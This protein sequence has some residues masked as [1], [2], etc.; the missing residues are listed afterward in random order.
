MAPRGAGDFGV[1]LSALRDATSAMVTSR[2][3]ADEKAREAV[4][5]VEASLIFAL[6]REALRGLPDLG[7][8]IHGLRIGVEGSQF[9]KLPRGRSV[10]VLDSKG[11]LVWA[12]MFASGTAFVQRAPRA[13]I[14]ASILVPYMGAVGRA[15][16]L[17]LRSAETRTEEFRHISALGEKIAAA[18]HLR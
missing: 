2:E 3:D 13:L 10:L 7:D 16:D 17:H 5:A 8:G 14:R 12:T 4:E 18:M 9:A 6:G 15:L 1:A 11:M